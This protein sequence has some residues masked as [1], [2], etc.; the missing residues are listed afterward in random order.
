ML[1]IS[2]MNKVSFDIGKCDNGAK[3]RGKQPVILKYKRKNYLDFVYQMII[4]K[5]IKF[6][7]SMNKLCY[8]IRN[9]FMVT[10]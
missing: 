7:S 2:D 10:S 4:R 3:H 1:V 9:E 8:F 6:M 5:I